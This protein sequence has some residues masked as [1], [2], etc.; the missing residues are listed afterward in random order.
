MEQSEFLTTQGGHLETLDIVEGVLCEP[1]AWDS[2]I[3]SHLAAL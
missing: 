1:D 2:E 3:S